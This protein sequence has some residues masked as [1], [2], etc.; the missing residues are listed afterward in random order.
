MRKIN[1]VFL[2]Y[3]RW[4]AQEKGKYATN[5]EKSNTC[6]PVGNHDQFILICW[7]AHRYCGQV[8]GSKR[9]KQN[10]SCMGLLIIVFFSTHADSHLASFDFIWSITLTQYWGCW[11]DTFA[12]CWEGWLINFYFAAC[13]YDYAADCNR[14]LQYRR[15]F[16]SWRKRTAKQS[17]GMYHRYIKY[18]CTKYFI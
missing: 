3:F 4:A 14:L 16:D 1:Q 18:K 17:S 8:C 9:S 15:S 6:K 10:N 7:S 13:P 12:S 2:N 5:Q 11:A